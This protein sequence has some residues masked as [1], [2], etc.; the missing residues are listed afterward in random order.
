M[1]WY[2]ESGGQQQG[3]VPDSELDRLLAEGRLNLDSLIWR[4]G[5]AGWAPMRTARPSI[6]VPAPARVPPM[7]PGLEVTRPAQPQSAGSGSDIP[8]P[9]WI[10]CTFT[11]RYFPPS[12]I[13]YLDGKPYSAGAKPQVIASMQGGAILPSPGFDLTGPPWEQRAQLGMV[14]AATETIKG[15]LLQPAV[16]FQ[17]M[18]REGGLQSPLLYNLIL[19]T[20]GIVV[21][22]LLIF[23]FQ[24]VMLGI[25][26]TSSGQGNVALPI[27]A[28]VVI[29]LVYIVMIPVAI[30]VSSFVQA[31]ILHLCLML[32]KG[33]NRPFE[34]TYRTLCYAAG[35]ASIL[36]VV[37]FLGPTVAGVWAIVALCIGL[38]KTQEITVG[39]ALL[40]IFLPTLACCGLAAVIGVIGGIAGAAGNLGR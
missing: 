25:A 2:Y 30:T 1:N 38:S 3:P 37:P 31:G 21:M 28:I 13:I 26:S 16:T 36:C 35:S 33:A 9:G 18:R 11:G 4:E 8:Q 34:T 5:M 32:V 23:G 12:E 10:R 14:K 39:K 27:A 22:V 29:M 15:V 24:L 40:A 19:G 20:I 7:D 6:A 17:N